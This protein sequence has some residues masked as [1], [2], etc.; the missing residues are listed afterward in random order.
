MSKTNIL[1]QIRAKYHELLTESDNK[2][3]VIINTGDFK[4]SIH[5]YQ[6]MVLLNTI[7]SDDYSI[8]HREIPLKSADFKTIDEYMTDPQVL[9]KAISGSRYFQRKGLPVRFDGDI[10]ITDPTYAVESKIWTTEADIYSGYGLDSVFGDDY[11]FGDT[12]YG[13]WSCTV[14]GVG[15][16]N[17]QK[18][19]SQYQASTGNLIRGLPVLGNFCADA[20]LVGVFYADRSRKIKSIPRHCWTRID[21]FHGTVQRYVVG[22]SVYI[23]G[24]SDSGRDNFVSI[25]TGL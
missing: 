12:I 8:E 23:I 3:Q 22:Q 9:K 4:F 1:D 24:F 20:G 2:N 17:P 15:S 13:D 10:I 25:Q 18:F 7:I 16:R 5:I 11:I 14:Y 6:D 21:D 19:I